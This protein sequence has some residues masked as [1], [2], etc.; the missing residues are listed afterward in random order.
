MEEVNSKEIT[1][2][3]EFDRTKKVRNFAEFFQSLLA[4]KDFVVC[5]T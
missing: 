5:S 1:K 3:K 2:N 4:E